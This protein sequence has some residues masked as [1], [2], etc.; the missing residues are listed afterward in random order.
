MNG[1]DGSYR[2]RMTAVDREPVLVRVAALL[3]ALAVVAVTGWW[4]GRVSNPPIPVPLLPTPAVLG[5]P[6]GSGMDRAVPGQDAPVVPIP[7]HV[8][9]PA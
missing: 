7:L 6:G 9:H 5:G 1:T 8:Q 2:V 4:A 3:T